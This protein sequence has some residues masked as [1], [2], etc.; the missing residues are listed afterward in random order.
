MRDAEKSGK[1]EKG[2]DLHLELSATKVANDFLEEV[3]SKSLM[4]LGLLVQD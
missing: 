3:S 2:K 4:E 1:G